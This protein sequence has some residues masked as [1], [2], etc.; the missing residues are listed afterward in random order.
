VGK[1]GKGKVM[2]V[3]LE[4]TNRIGSHLKR[5]NNGPIE[6]GRFWA[7]K[8]ANDLSSVDEEM[9]VDTAIHYG[10]LWMKSVDSSTWT[11][12]RNESD[13]PIFQKE[14]RDDYQSCRIDCVVVPYMPEFYHK[15]YELYCSMCDGVGTLPDG[16]VCPV[17]DGNPEII[18]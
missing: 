9:S 12:V 7:L 14:Y 17:C 8:D 1:Q 13:I 2:S 16:Y 6:G 11:E 5:K 18:K 15:A 10:R 3:M 4:R